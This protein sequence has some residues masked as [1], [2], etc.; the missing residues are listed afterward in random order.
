LKSIGQK[1]LINSALMGLFNPFL[2]YVVLF[3]AYSMIEAQ[4]A[5]ALNYIWPMM[6]VVFSIIFLKQK[7]SLMSFLAIMVSF[8]GTIV[9]ATHGQI[10]S[11]RFSNPIGSLLA[12]GSSIFWASFFVLNMKDPREAYSKMFMNFVFGF[13]YILA[14]NLISGKI[15]VPPFQGIAGSVYIGIFEMGLTFVLWLT[16]LNLS[17]TTVRVSNLVYLSPFLSL[18]MVSIFVG[19]KILPSTIAG[20]VIIVG[21]ILLQQWSFTQSAE[22]RAKARSARREG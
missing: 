9:I 10:G 12:A 22:S 13:F 6:L 2:Y 4:E 20:L 21:A 3:K 8:F 16:A 7:T 14:L 19:E 15:S 1:G 18:M 17:T 5:V 11:L